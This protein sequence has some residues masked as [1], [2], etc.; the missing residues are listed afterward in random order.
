MGFQENYHVE[1]Q[2]TE[3][4][5][6]FVNTQNTDVNI[7]VVTP[8]IE[9]GLDRIITVNPGS[10]AYITVSYSLHCIGSGYQNKGMLF[11]YINKYG[12]YAYMQIL[13]IF[14]P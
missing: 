6:Y 11:I 4:R 7:T 8:L 9:Q 14:L 3:G 13:H 12:F 1:G 2:L 5:L 10:V